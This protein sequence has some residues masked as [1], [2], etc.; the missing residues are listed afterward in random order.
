MRDGKRDRESEGKRCR[1]RQRERR[2][3]GEKGK[4]HIRP[5]AVEM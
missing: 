2:R 5:L 3:D 4:L 1:D